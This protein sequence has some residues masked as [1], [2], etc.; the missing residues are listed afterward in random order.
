MPTSDDDQ[1]DNSLRDKLIRKLTG[2]AP[3]AVERE[4]K[5]GL[6]DRLRW[7]EK[8]HKGD[9]KAAAK[10]AG[11]S[12]TTWRRWRSGKQKPKPD[13]VAKLDKATRD[14]LVPKGRRKRISEST[15]KGRGLSAG[16]PSGGAQMSAWV[17]ISSDTRPRDLN[18]GGALGPGRLD[19][20]VNA[21][22]EFGEDAA[23]LELKKAIGEYLHVDPEDVNIHDVSGIDWEPLRNPKDSGGDRG[24]GGTDDQGEIF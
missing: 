1:Q 3:G 16:A 11:I 9:D 2:R 18:L 13:S 21:Y 20:V 4:Q 17:T 6:G 15:G 8:K 23:I 24:S 12:L 10:A 7:L 19:A 14:A 5:K 22:V